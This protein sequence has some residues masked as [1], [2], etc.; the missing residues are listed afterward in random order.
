M[1]LTEECKRIIAGQAIET[2]D[3][4]LTNRGKRKEKSLL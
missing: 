2:F 3:L 4:F 1:C